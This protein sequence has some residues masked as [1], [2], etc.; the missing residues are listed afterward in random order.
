MKIIKY[1]DAAG[2][3]PPRASSKVLAF[4]ARGR[5]YKYVHNGIIVINAV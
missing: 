1:I 2:A 3:R 5:K 4:V